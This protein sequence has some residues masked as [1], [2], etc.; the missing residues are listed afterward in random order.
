MRDKPATQR[1]NLTLLRQAQ[2]SLQALF[3]GFPLGFQSGHLHRS[4]HQTIFNCNACTHDVPS[5]TETCLGRLFS[6]RDQLVHR[7]PN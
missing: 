6:R 5:F 1:A 4:T 7:F 3:N 2:Q